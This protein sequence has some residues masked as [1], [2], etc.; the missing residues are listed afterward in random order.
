[1]DKVDADTLHPDFE[2]VLADRPIEVQVLYRD[3]RRAILD[4]CPSSNELLYHT[5][6]LSSVYSVSRQL[7]HAFCHI[8]VYAGH[9]NLGFNAGSQLDDPAGLLQGSGS[10]IRHVPITTADDLKNPELITLMDAALAHAL[11]LLGKAPSDKNLLISK[12]KT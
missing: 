2:R 6:A 5:H 3:V 12:I 10:L 1:V 4:V 8:P 9:L 7:K 11:E